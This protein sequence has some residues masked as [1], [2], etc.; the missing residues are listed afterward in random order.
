MTDKSI[1]VFQDLHL[2]TRSPAN[3]I[4]AAILAQVQKPWCHD[5]EREDDIRGHAGDGEDVIVLVRD[6]FD[7][8]DESGIVLWQEGGGDRISIR[9]RRVS[10]GRGLHRADHPT[11]MLLLQKTLRCVIPAK[12]S[13]QRIGSNASRN[14]VSYPILPHSDKPKSNSSQ[15]PN[16]RR[17]AAR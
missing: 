9:L 15:C 14:K 7:D 11:R 6:A 1:E 12:R 17:N 2:K 4:R 8:V 5:L 16:M 10:A 13:Q 3:S